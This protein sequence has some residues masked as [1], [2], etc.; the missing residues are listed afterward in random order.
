MN[1]R[2]PEN[3]YRPAPDRA[4]QRRL[5]A[6]FAACAVVLSAWQLF[7]LPGTIVKRYDP[8]VDMP[9]YGFGL[10]GV[11]VEQ[12]GRWVIHREGYADRMRKYK[13][14]PYGTLAKF[15]ESGVYDQQLDTSGGK[16]RGVRLPGGGVLNVKPSRHFYGWLKQV[17]SGKGQRTSSGDVEIPT[18]EPEQAIPH[19]AGGLPSYAQPGAGTDAQ[20]PYVIARV[21]KHDQAQEYS[22]LLGYHYYPV[23]DSVCYMAPYLWI[24]TDRLHYLH[25]IYLDDSTGP[26]VI[27]EE[28]TLPLDLGVKVEHDTSLGVDHRVGMLY[29]VL[30]S[31]ERFWFDIQQAKLARKDK[32][33]GVWDAEYAC[34][35]DPRRE[36]SFD[37]GYP[38]TK[39][40]YQLVLRCLVV[41]FLGSLLYLAVQWRQ[42][43]K[44]IA[45][46]TT[47]ASNSSNKS[48][49]TST[50]SGTPA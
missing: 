31:G 8:P 42:A 17:R 2:L 44:Y 48:S 16:G 46:A 32:L 22:V 47:G 35:G 7:N 12:D 30:S 43:W 29:L 14:S 33:P 38:L 18:P 37:R 36:Y 27:R 19:S 20:T 15:E 10:A 24:T 5:L 50:D 4:G 28:K 9:W 25:R 39:A 13:I 6:L 49:P 3:Y 23:F 21:Y 45:A 11:F 26:T 34:L 41:V 40:Q 1:L